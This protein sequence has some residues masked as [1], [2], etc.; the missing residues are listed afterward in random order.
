M[1]SNEVIFVVFIDVLLWL[2]GGQWK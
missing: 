1:L 2:T